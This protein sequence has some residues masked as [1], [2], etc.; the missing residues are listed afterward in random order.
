M[1]SALIYCKEKSFIIFNTYSAG[2]EKYLDDNEIDFQESKKVAVE[3]ASVE[4]QQVNEA[5]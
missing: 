2:L 1:T 5:N 4:Q 3:E